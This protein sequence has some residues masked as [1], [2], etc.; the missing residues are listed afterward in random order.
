MLANSI[1]K[2]AL[3]FWDN[4]MCDLC[5]LSAGQLFMSAAQDTPS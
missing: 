1:L 4:V 5:V 2:D 3:P